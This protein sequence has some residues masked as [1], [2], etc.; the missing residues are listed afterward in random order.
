MSDNQNKPGNVYIKLC[1]I[2]GKV[3]PNLEQARNRARKIRLLDRIF[4]LLN[5]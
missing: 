3:E 4:F 1:K 5:K 2:L